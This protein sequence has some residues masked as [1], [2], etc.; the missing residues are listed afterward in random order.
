M[1]FEAFYQRDDPTNNTNKKK[2]AMT[3]TNTFREN[4]Q[5]AIFETLDQW[6]KA[7]S[8][9]TDLFFVLAAG[10][11]QV[12]DSKAWVRCVSGNV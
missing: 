7:E 9:E 12:L 4:L 3:I 8:A 10:T 2:K 11:I 6:T 1:T 5:R